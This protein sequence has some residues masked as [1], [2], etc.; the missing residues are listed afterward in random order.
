MKFI[1]EVV[2]VI[3]RWQRYK[4]WYLGWRYC[5]R[6]ASRAFWKSG[7]VDNPVRLS[8]HATHVSGTLIA[9]GIDPNAKGMAFEAEL[10]GL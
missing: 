7:A 6:Y 4:F 10:K 9:T 2:W 3:L 1:V 8:S 5:E